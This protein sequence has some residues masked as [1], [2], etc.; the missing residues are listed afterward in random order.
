[1]TGYRVERC[2]GT[3]C[4]NFPQI[5]SRPRRYNNTGLTGGTTYRYRVRA[6]DAAGNLSPYSNDR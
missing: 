2:Q 5:G 6:A 3:S 4:T 1:M